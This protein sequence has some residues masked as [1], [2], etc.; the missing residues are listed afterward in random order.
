[1]QP[2]QTQTHH[3]A[4]LVRS[5]CS[6]ALTWHTENRGGLGIAQ[7]L[8]RRRGVATRNDVGIK[9]RISERKQ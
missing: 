1:M 9:I 2:L 3:A 6:R 8:E 7:F 5:C 4:C